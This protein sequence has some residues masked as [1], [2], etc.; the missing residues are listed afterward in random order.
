MTLRSKLLAIDAVALGL[1]AVFALVTIAIARGD[2]W[3]SAPD[4]AGYAYERQEADQC[5]DV[6][7][8]R[9]GE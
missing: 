7:F 3:H 6:V 2:R 5:A 8:A 4:C 9:E 1:F